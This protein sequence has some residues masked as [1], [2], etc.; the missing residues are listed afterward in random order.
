MPS[1]VVYRREQVKLDLYRGLF[2]H[3][4]PSSQSTR[5]LKIQP[6]IFF[7]NRTKRSYLI[8]WSHDPSR[9]HHSSYDTLKCGFNTVFSFSDPNLL[10]LYFSDL[11]FRKTPWRVGLSA[12]YY[13]S[14]KLLP[15]SSISQ[16]K[17]HS[18]CSTPCDGQPSSARR[19]LDQLRS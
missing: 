17:F 10:N 7:E 4:K 6:Q 14:K 16:G 1:C 11:G 19:N 13:W 5:A 18:I 12:H 3:E 2:L 9:R 15:L 8:D